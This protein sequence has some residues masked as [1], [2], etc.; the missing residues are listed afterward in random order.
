[1]PDIK[2]IADK[3]D[4]IINGQ[5]ILTKQKPRK[6]VSGVDGV[7]PY[8]FYSCINESKYTCLRCCTNRKQPSAITPKTKNLKISRIIL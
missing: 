4:I 7:H 3:A 6:P 5:P 8:F 2:T 1:M